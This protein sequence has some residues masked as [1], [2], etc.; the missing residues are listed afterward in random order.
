MIRRTRRDVGRELPPLSRIPYTIESDPKALHRI[1][2]SATE[3]ARI[4]LDR[5][6]DKTTEERWTAAGQFDMLMRQATGIA[7]APYAADFV[8]MLV[9]SGERVLLYGWHREVYDIWRERLRDLNPVMFTGSESPHMKEVSKEA[10]LKGSTHVMIMSLRSGQGLDGLQKVSR[11]AVFGELDWSPGIHEQCIGRVF[12]DGQ[13]EPVTAYFL[14]AKDGS[15]PVVA[16][17]LGIKREQVEGIRD[18]QG[19][20]AERL[21]TDGKEI[22]RLAAEYLKSRGVKYVE[23]APEE[24]PLFDVSG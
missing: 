6:L 18:P 21:Q 20:L 19:A 16:D 4:I 15:D 13:K 8:R 10:F 11:T 7:K 22:R 5:A 17:V 1:S 9:E 24:P 12:R 2:G 23:V 3:L 14:M